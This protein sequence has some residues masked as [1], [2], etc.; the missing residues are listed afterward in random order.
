MYILMLKAFHP[1]I[2]LLPLEHEVSAPLVPGIGASISKLI[3]L[4][5]G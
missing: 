5:Q 4:V 2:Q 3:F 1:G